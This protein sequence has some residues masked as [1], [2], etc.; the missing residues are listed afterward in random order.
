MRV[1]DLKF[2]DILIKYDRKR[3]VDL[4]RKTEELSSGKALLYPSDSPVDYARVIRLKNIVSGFERFNR[5]IDLTQN[6]LETAESVLGTVVNTAQTVRVKIVQLLNT[7]VLNEEDAKVMVDY[8]ESI[9]DYIIQQGNTKIGDSYLF[10]GVKTQEAPFSSD[11]SYNGETT[12]TTVPVA[13]GV[14]VNTNFNGKNYFGVNSAS[15]SG[16]I[17]IVEVLDTIITLIKNGE[18]SQLNTY[19]IDVD[20]DGSGTPTKMKLL[21][22]FDAGLSKIMEYRS[23]IGTKIATVENLRIQNESL[24]VH[25]SNL[26]SKIEDTD[27]AAAISEYEKAKTAYEAL[28]AAIQQTK[29]LSLL[30]FYR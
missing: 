10:G 1:P 2:F 22:A 5:N 14:T 23:I 27:Y 12:E 16:K 26:I 25:Y 15:G 6:I 19:E 24:R 20:L 7:G 21:D 29:D 17:L 30:K 11:G 4:T 9:K 8:L 28:I 13:N 3:S 18:Y